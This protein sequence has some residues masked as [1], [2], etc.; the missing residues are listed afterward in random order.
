[1]LPDLS[2]PLKKLAIKV[3]NPKEFSEKWAKRLAPFSLVAAVGI[4]VI[5]AMVF[6]TQG[7]RDWWHSAALAPDFIAV[8]L[9]SGTAIV[10][11]AS[12]ITYGIKEQYQQAY[13]TMAIFISVAFFIHLFIMYND[14]FNH[15]WYGADGALETLSVTFKDYTLTHLVEVAAPLAA[16]ILLLSSGVR[17]SAGAIISSCCLLIIGV[18]AHRF[19]LMPGAFDRVPLTIP[20]LGLQNVEWSVPIASGRYDQALNTFVTEWH[21]F[22]SGVEIAIF[23]GVVAYMCFLMMLAVDRLPIVKEAES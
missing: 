9:T 5:T 12:V 7:G 8:A 4:H 6:A 22:P 13:R 11:V 17:K 10:L 21:Y 20:P 23:V 2:G 15:A 16:V 19:L 18:F 14:F 3:D 1:M